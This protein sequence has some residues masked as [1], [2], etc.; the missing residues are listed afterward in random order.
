MARIVVA[1]AIANKPLS[2]GEA[3]VRLSWT[4][5]LARLGHDVRLVEQLPAE[6]WKTGVGRDYFGETVRSFGLERRAALVR[7]EG[8]ETDGVAWDDLL[9]FAAD[10]DLLVNI[11]GHL[12]SRPL[13]ER[14]ACR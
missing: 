10:A 9:A 2:G 12:T 5:G 7:E 11:S 8:P 6:A 4:L 1:G 3:W 13:M 14:I